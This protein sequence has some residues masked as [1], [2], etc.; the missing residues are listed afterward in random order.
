ME[1]KLVLLVNDTMT[2]RLLFSFASVIVVP[3]PPHSFVMRK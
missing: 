1:M 2:N 3:T